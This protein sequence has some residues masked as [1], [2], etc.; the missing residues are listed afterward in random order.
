MP[1]SA[2]GTRGQSPGRALPAWRRLVKP[3]LF[4]A[5]AAPLAALLLRAFSVGGLSLGANPIEAIMDQLGQW[6]LRLLLLT[7]LVTPLAVTLHKPWI[8]KVRRMVGLFAFGYIALHFLTWLILD[9]W[10]EISAIIEDI[11][12]RP[13]ITVGFAAF[14]M[15]IPLAVTSTAGWMRRLGRR[16]HSLHRLIYPAAILGCV[17]FWWQ[18]KADIREPL[19]YSVILALLLGWRLRRARQLSRGASLRRGRAPQRG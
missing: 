10:L 19:L 8:L 18:V 12:K 4:V 7:L 14:L 1:V 3:L 6:G 11:G 16:W 2:A 13:F 5:C 17:H 15:L 9:K